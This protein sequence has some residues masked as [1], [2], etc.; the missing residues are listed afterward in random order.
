MHIFKKIST[1]VFSALAFVTLLI[2]CSTTETVSQQRYNVET[3]SN[4][5]MVNGIEM[6][7]REAGEG[8]PIILIHGW[9]LSSRLFAGNISALAEDYHVIAPDLRGF[10]KTEMMGNPSEMRIEGYAQDVLAMMDELGIEQAVI[11]GMSMGGPIAFSMYEQAPD[12]FTALLL[13]DTIAAAAPP[14][15]KHLWLG[16]A[17]NIENNGVKVIPKQAMDEMLTAE[18][19]MNDSSAVNH[20]AGIMKN[21]SKEGAMAGAYALSNRS[22]FMPLLSEISVPTLIIVGLQDS[23]YPYEFAKR[24]QKKISDSE[25]AILDNANHAAIFEAADRANEGILTW[26]N[27]M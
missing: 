27:E 4:Y 15:E 9:P 3:D 16:W 11:G 6:F 19:R 5:V 14:Q 7:Y 17:I 23:I 22:N 26:L 24:M 25:L 21:A 8:T 10:G 2:A 12:R 13:M 18:T 20:I 1:L